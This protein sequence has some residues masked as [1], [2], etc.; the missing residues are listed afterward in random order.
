M[1]E[2]ADNQLPPQVGVHLRFFNW[3]MYQA[4][5]QL[6]INQGDLALVVGCSQ[7]HIGHIERLIAWPSAALAD[8][9]AVV[10]GE[11]IESLFPQALFDRMQASK[12]LPTSVRFPILLDTISLYSPEC[13]GLLTDG[14]LDDK[15]SD[16]TAAI[17][18]A[19]TSLK[20]REQHVLQLRFGLD[21]GRQWTL[22]EVGRELGVT[23]GRIRQIE[24]KALRK[25][26]H[27]SRSKFLRG[28]IE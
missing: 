23:R 7:N 10:L 19:L 27:P 2:T 28:F 22:E 5:K 14:G 16:L 8:E 3:Q 13:S 11:T 26:R 12:G 4:R 9:I 6:G 24:A 18:S 1:T 17:T 25:M 20:P 15:D 21:D